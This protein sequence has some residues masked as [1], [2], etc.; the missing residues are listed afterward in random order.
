MNLVDWSS[1]NHLAVALGAYVYLWNAATGEIH[2]LCQLEGEGDGV[3]GEY[4]TSVKWA[5]E[6][7]YLALGSSTGDVQ[8]W[9]VENMKKCKVLKV[10]YYYPNSTHKVH[11]QTE[12]G[13][14]VIT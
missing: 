2:Q 12:K 10:K 13:Q 3:E 1:H 8:L 5:K 9:D 7:G 11:A 6:S 4:V 14:N